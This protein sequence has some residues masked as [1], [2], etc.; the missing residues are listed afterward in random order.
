VSQIDA[1]QLKQSLNSQLI[2]PT[3]AFLQLQMNELQ[4]RNNFDRQRGALSR[5]FFVGIVEPSRTA[6]L[7]GIG[8]LLAEAIFFAGT[9]LETALS[10]ARPSIGS[11]LVSTA[12]RWQ[13]GR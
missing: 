1:S 13:Q 3:T 5:E 9:H 10:S 4:Q 7:S 11:F 2:Q 6:K 8:F 12:H